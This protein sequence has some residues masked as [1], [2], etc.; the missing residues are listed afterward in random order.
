MIGE[1]GKFRAR[2]W[3]KEKVFE[4]NLRYL[5]YYHGEPPPYRFMILTTTHVFS[6][7]SVDGVHPITKS[8]IS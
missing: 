8:S 1:I 4:R 5:I 2:R 7:W 3:R 6:E